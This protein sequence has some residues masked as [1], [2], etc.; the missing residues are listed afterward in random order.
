M[1]PLVHF[2]AVILLVPQLL[3]FTA[4]VILGHII[5][6]RTF[7]SFFN[8]SLDV[9]DTLF[10]W[11]GLAVIVVTVAVLVAGFSNQWRPFAAGL[12]IFLAVG[13]TVWLLVQLWPPTELG[14]L[15]LFAP[16]AFATVLSASLL[17]PA[18]LVNEKA[19]QR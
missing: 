11:G 17:R 10:G 16:A 9:L 1:R 19:A 6:G 13:T 2:V 15:L 14:Q 8:R 4:F 5:G 7:G 18:H 3:L 12:L